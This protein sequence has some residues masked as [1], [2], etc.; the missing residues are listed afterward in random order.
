MGDKV[1]AKHVV[2]TKDKRSIPVSR[3]RGTHYSAATGA[4]NQTFGEARHFV[5]TSREGGPDNYH[6]IQEIYVG[7]L[8][9]LKGVHDRCVKYNIKDPLKIPLMFNKTMTDPA[10]RWGD[11]TTKRDLLVHW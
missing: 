2:V 11:A 1:L 10:V 3:E 4:L 6:N 9:K 8:H 5:P 7:N